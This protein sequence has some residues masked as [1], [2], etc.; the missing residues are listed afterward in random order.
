MLDCSFP[1]R[2]H[3]PKGHNDL[4]LALAIHH[5]LQPYQTLLT[6]LSDDMDNWLMDNPDSL[7]PE[8]KVARDGMSL[9]L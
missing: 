8:V 3:P 4:K 7:P 5:D 2:E 1:P 6:H 9:N